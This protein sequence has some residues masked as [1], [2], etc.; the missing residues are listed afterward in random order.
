M[1]A[2]PTQVVEA[3]AAS[4]AAAVAVVVWYSGWRDRRHR[5]REQ[6]LQRDV[7]QI[8]GADP[9]RPGTARTDRD[10]PSV[11]DRLDNIHETVAANRRVSDR[12]ALALWIHISD[13][14]GHPI[15]EDLLAEGMRDLATYREKRTP[16]RLPYQT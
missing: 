13:H 5:Q 12:F 4:V 6:E 15:P 10:H 2:S 11:I 1:T 3:C 9:A 16:T 7:A 8:L 14:H